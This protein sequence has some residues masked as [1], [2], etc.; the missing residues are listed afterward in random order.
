MNSNNFIKG[1]NPRIIQGEIFTDKDIPPFMSM[2]EWNK[3]H[4]IGN[5][6]WIQ[7]FVDNR[8]EFIM[9]QDNMINVSGYTQPE[10]P[11]AEFESPQA[12]RDYITTKVNPDYD[13]KNTTHWGQQH[14]NAFDDA[15]MA[16]KSEL[17]VPIED[18]N[19]TAQDYGPNA[20]GHGSILQPFNPN[21]E[22]SIKTLPDF[23]PFQYD[24]LAAMPSSTITPLTQIPTDQKYLEKVPVVKEIKLNVKRIINEMVEDQLKDTQLGNGKM[25][26]G[27]PKDFKYKAGMEVQ[28][29]NPDCPHR[30]SRGI[31]TK[32]GNGDVTYK[33]TNW[34]RYFKPGDELTKSVDQMIPLSSENKPWY[35]A[36]GE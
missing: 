28:D 19:S 10:F 5:K 3:K 11:T 8:S 14:Q 21:K 33:V 23:E 35:I 20:T 1:K 36:G 25:I 6:K 26:S 24:N 31:V 30:D 13:W 16:K 17:V 34:G 32:A 4:N 7:E 15:T 12:M 29:I 18:P 9:E 27:K 22:T 2:K